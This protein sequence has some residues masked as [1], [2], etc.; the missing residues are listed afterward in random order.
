M[1]PALLAT[2]A[3]TVVLRSILVVIGALQGGASAV[4]FNM[5]AT[6]ALVLGTLVHMWAQLGE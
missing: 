6:A 1:R 2:L 3:C 4:P 5:A